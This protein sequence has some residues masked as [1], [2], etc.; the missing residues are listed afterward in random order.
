ME[1][2]LHFPICLHGFVLRY[3]GNCLECA[4]L[5][6]STSICRP[7]GS[8]DNLIPA[9]VFIQDVLFKNTIMT[10]HMNPFTHKTT[11]P[12]VILQQYPIDTAD[13]LLEIGTT[14][15]SSVLSLD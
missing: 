8:S 4:R 15:I 7:E 14:L 2:S 12:M 6:M 1:F 11:K 9:I 10:T 13:T 5:S 3:G